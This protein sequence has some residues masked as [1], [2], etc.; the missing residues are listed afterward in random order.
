MNN[1]QYYVRGG[2]IAEPSPQ[3]DHLGRPITYWGGLANERKTMT[4]TREEFA[5]R[6]VNGGKDT[7]G[8]G[9]I[10]DDMLAF[11]KELIPV[12]LELF[13]NCPASRRKRVAERGPRRGLLGVPYNVGMMRIHAVLEDRMSEPQYQNSG[14]ALAESLVCQVGC[15]EKEELESLL[16]SAA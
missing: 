6:V 8:A 12:L 15:C 7:F 9:S 13:Q 11:V 14:V 5:A 1:I 3:T 2:I 4:M 10:L 16:Q